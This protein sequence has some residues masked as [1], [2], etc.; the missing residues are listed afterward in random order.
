MLMAYL[1]ISQSDDRVVNSVQK[2]V[3]DVLLFIIVAFF[4]LFGI[5]KLN[6]KQL[7]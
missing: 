1:Y 3:D 6:K 7:I 5:P 2:S 4:F